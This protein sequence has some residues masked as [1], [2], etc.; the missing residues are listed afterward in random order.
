MHVRSLVKATILAEIGMALLIGLL[1]L[2]VRLLL[3]DDWT[4]G[5]PWGICIFGATGVSGDYYRRRPPNRRRGVLAGLAV[6]G[7]LA[8]AIT[9]VADL[10]V[11]GDLGGNVY[12]GLA[13]MATLP[14]ANGVFAYV[15]G[16]PT[17]R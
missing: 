13:L 9:T 5:M 2:A 4:Q 10:W 12:V 11:P 6:L 3:G 16:P 8:V 14:V 1:A 7:V 15:A 17:A